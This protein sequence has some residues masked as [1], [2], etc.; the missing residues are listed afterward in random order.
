[1]TIETQNIPVILF[2]AN[3]QMGKDSE[4]CQAQAF[5]SMPSDI[6]IITLNSKEKYN[7]YFTSDTN[8]FRLEAIGAVKVKPADDLPF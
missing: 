3:V 8:L 7:A 5:I 2:P 4:D 6:Q 1:M